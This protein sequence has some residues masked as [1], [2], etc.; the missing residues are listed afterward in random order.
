MWDFY[1]LLLN[2]LYGKTIENPERRTKVKLCNDPRTYEEHIGKP[3]FKSA[4][5]INGQL[6][7]V[8][9]KCSAIKINKPFYIGM[10]ILDL[11]K[12]HMYNFHYNVMKPIFGERI[13]LLYTNTDSLMYEIESEDVYKELG[14]KASGYFDFSNYPEDHFFEK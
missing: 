1:K 6:V 11:S 9:M 14:M 12:W 13:N 4:K 2:S 8:E 3:N 7:G 10:S 5:I